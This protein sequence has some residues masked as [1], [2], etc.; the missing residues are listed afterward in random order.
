VGQRKA[1]KNC[2]CGLAEEEAQ[3]ANAP[4]TSAPAVATAAAPKPMK[5]A[6][7][8]VRAPLRMSRRR[9]DR[10][11]VGHSQQSICVYCSC[12]RSA[13]WVMLSG[14]AGARTWVNR[15]SRRGPMQSSCSCNVCSTA[16]QSTRALLCIMMMC[17]YCFLATEGNQS[18]RTEMYS[19]SATRFGLLELQV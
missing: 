3:A 8:N 11:Y 7:G 12:C 6:C 14:A 10:V 17:I 19:H 1:C 4:V 15:H 13:R 18:F 5:S 2:S 16:G 9:L